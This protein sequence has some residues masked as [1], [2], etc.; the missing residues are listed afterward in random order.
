M[1]SDSLYTRQLWGSGLPADYHYGE[2]F[3]RLNVDICV[4]PRIGVTGAASFSQARSP[5]LSPWQHKDLACVHNHRRER[6]PV[7]NL[8]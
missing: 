3:V 2:H 1:R 8:H 6:R 4:T 5:P 7:T